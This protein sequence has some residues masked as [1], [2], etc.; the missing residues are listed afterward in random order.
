MAEKD[1]NSWLKRW[2][3][4]LIILGL[5]LLPLLLCSPIAFFSEEAVVSGTAEEIPAFRE[6][7]P[8]AG[9][10]S[11]ET[12]RKY[13][14][15]VQDTPP[16]QLSKEQETQIQKLGLSKEER[17]QCEKSLAVVLERV[18]E[19]DSSGQ[20]AWLLWG[21]YALLLIGGTVFCAFR[22]KHHPKKS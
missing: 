15:I 17:T 1:R 8:F 2:G 14:E 11:L 5:L 13:A 7:N 16:D 3:I 22:R 12:I 20:T 10:A 19:A 21:G 18:E 9:S 4:L 6:E